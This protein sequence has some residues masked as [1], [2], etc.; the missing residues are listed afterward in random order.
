MFLGAHDCHVT[1]Q[2]TNPAGKRGLVAMYD[3]AGN[4]MLQGLL[5][6]DFLGG[7]GCDLVWFVLRY[8]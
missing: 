5:T 1:F 7:W 6:Y 2:L 8:I 4:F 3:V